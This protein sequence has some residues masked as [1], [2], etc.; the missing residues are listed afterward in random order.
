MILVF[1]FK[2]DKSSKSQLCYLLIQVYCVLV[3]VCT[4]PVDESLLSRHMWPRSPGQ[5]N[6]QT[7]AGSYFT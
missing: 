1:S 2:I 7:P 5:E 3:L 6:S 4:L